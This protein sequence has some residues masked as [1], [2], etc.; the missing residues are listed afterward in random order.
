MVA[1]KK[2]ISVCLSIALSISIIVL[3]FNIVLKENV[4][5]ESW[6]KNTASELGLYKEIKDKVEENLKY[7]TTDSNITDNDSIY[8]NIVTDEYI[9]N[10]VDKILDENFKAINN[11][12]YNKDVINVDDIINVYNKRIYDYFVSRNVIMDDAANE[13]IGTIKLEA[14]NEV[15]TAISSI[16]F[17]TFL[18]AHKN[19]STLNLFFN[20]SVLS[21]ANVT[22]FCYIVMVIT[23]LGIL[24]FNLSHLSSFLNFA[25]IAIF[26]GGAIP[27]S[28]GYGGSLSKISDNILFMGSTAN[29]LLTEL[30]NSCFKILTIYGGVFVIIGALCAIASSITVSVSRRIRAK[31]SLDKTSLIR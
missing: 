18:E 2:L 12:S 28:I 6:Y 24:I 14:Q 13:V 31:S 8:Q 11:E 4:F 19:S 15:T 26:I 7:V 30:V 25:G 1:F 21:N 29:E 23:M 10:E 17:W 3:I 9:N 20:L 16:N 27:F 5:N 22:T